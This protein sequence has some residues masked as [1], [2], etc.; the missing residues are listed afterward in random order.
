MIAGFRRCAARGYGVAAMTK[1]YDFAVEDIVAA[2]RILS[3]ENVVDAYGHV[4]MRHPDN[5]QRFLLSRARAPEA[6][7]ADDIME[8]GMDGEPVDARGRRPYLES[9]IHAAIY[10]VRPDVQS[11]VHSHSRD[12]I[13]FGVTGARLR[14]VMHTCASIGYDIPVWDTQPKFGDTDML[15]SNIAMT[16]SVRFPSRTRFRSL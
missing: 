7:V 15:V 1:E 9:F 5:A 2:N 14:P 10:E 6:I 3:R 16:A 11:V 4:S 13:P 8:F 12:V